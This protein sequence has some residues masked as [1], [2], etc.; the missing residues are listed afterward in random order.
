MHPLNIYLG[1]SP[2]GTV[3]VWAQGPDCGFPQ[4]TSNPWKFWAS[5]K[6]WLRSGWNIEQQGYFE[7]SHG[8]SW[9]WEFDI[10]ILFS[11]INWRLQYVLVSIVYI[12]GLKRV[13]INRTALQSVVS[14]AS[15]S[16]SRQSCITSR[17]PVHLFNNREMELIKDAVFIPPTDLQL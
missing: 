17:I 13:I 15:N 5:S 4:R 11:I 12:L 6:S 1:T 10:Y 9:R 16:S 2:V 7:Y 8:S 14:H 3:G